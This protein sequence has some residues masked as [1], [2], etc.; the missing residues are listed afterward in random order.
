MCPEKVGVFWFG[1]VSFLGL[2][3]VGVLFLCVGGCCFLWLT[4]DPPALASFCLVGFCPLG[5]LI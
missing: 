4:A 1:F 2:R 5:W 3:G